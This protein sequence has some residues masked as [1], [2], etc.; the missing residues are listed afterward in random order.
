MP[1][2]GTAKA[3]VLPLPV[4]A[5]PRTSR[6]ASASG[7]VADWIGNGVVIPVR[8]SA[9]AIGAG[10][11]NAANDVG[12]CAGGCG[13]GGC[14]ATSWGA[15]GRCGCGEGRDSRLRR[16]RPPPWGLGDKSLPFESS[17]AVDAAATRS[18]SRKPWAHG[19]PA[20]Q[21]APTQLGMAT[22]T[23]YRLRA[24]EPGPR[25]R[26][27][28]SKLGSTRGHERLASASRRGAR[29][30]CLGRDGVLELVG[31]LVGNSSTRAGDTRAGDIAA[32]DIND[33]GADGCDRVA[34]PSR[35]HG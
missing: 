33:I 5:R 21:A 19:A 2:R 34:L 17:E 7:R 35:R 3:I 16:G 18:S 15:A 14:G 31:K 11:P 1:A 29:D 20:L 10:T 30:R 28:V 23:P 4:R 8:A 9:A 32:R 13:A 12:S 22:G 25:Q 26:G 24:D 27:W 6:P